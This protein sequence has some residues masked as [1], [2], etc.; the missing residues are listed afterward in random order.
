MFFAYVY[1]DPLDQPK[2]IM[3]QFYSDTWRHR[4]YWGENLIPWGDE[5]TPTRLKIG[6]LPEKGKWVRLE[7][8]ADKLGLKSGMT[9]VAASGDADAHLTL[10]PASPV[11]ITG[12]YLTDRL[13]DEALKYL[14]P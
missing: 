12:E 11:S 1:I 4:A 8:E 9:I 5:N 10:S 7:V 6:A 14:E 2:E 3:L 13:G